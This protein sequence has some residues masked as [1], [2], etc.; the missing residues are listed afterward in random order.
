MLTSLLLKLIDKT[1]TRRIIL[2]A[3]FALSGVNHAANFFIYIVLSPRFRQLLVERLQPVID[4]ATRCFN[5]PRRRNNALCRR[6]A[7]TGDPGSRDATV[8]FSL[9]IYDSRAAY[10]DS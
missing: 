3:A 2:N 1:P 9:Q 6:C 5:L 8:Q 4:V 7:D 10:P